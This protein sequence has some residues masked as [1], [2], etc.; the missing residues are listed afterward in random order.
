MAFKYIE[1]IGKIISDPGAKKS[2]IET[3]LLWEPHITLVIDFL[4]EINSF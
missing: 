2:F 3:E 1:N 4:L